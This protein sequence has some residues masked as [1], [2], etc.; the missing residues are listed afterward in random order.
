MRDIQ[1]YLKI[2]ECKH[3]YLY[4]L[5]SR[6]L[7]YG[8]YN[9]ENSGFIGI[10]T[11]FKSRYLFTEYHWDTGSPFGTVKP[12]KEIEPCQQKIIIADNLGSECLNCFELVDFNQDRKWFHLKYNNCDTIRPCTR[13]NKDLFEYL[14]L[15]INSQAQY[16]R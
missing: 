2:Q 1:Q 9:S 5:H 10:R 12:S 13:R 16:G 8:V 4:E 6:N 7:T 11:K 14:D 3:G 15:Y